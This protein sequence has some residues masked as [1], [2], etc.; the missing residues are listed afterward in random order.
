MKKKSLLILG[1]LVLAIGLTVFAVVMNTD[2]S[3]PRFQF[4][5][6][7]SSEDVDIRI[8][9]NN[10]S[11]NSDN[12]DLPYSYEWERNSFFPFGSNF[13]YIRITSEDGEE[14]IL[15]VYRRGR[16]IKK[17]WSNSEIEYY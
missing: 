16:L 11:V 8:K 2:Y 4:K 3:Q 9:N 14:I 13:N 6:S 7:G 17:I 15:E 10:I 12:V 1:V 5:V